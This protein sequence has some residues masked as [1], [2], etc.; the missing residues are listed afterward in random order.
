MLLC[1]L[2]AADAKA[3][4]IV[5]SGNCGADGDNLTWTLDDDGLLTISGEGEMADYS[6][7]SSNRSPWYDYR[8]RILSVSIGDSV[9]SIGV[10]AF[11]ATA[12]VMSIMTV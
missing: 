5:A 3:A 10:R 9:T 7:S 11:V 8:S 12:C 4:E 2:P 1:V 6:S